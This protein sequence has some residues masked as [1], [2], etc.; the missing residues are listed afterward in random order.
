MS[1]GLFPTE[2]D[3]ANVLPLYNADDCM[4]FN[5]YRLVPILCILSKV[6]EKVMNSRLIDFLEEIKILIVNQF[7][8]RKNTHHG[9]YGANW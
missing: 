4:V 2:L 1:Q 3:I 5:K 6:S 8:F 7:G 9:P